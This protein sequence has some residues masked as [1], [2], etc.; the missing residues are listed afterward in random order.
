MKTEMKMGKSAKSLLKKAAVET[1]AE[2]RSV[3]PRT[4]SPA[5]TT[6][7][8]AARDKAIY[9]LDARVEE[10]EVAKF[11]TDRAAHAER[12]FQTRKIEAP[13]EAHR[14]EL[15]A[16]PSVERSRAVCGWRIK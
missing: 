15:V 16:S 14:D 7:A 3:E 11:A 6:K 4:E 13:A 1:A 8:T 10:L 2:I 9:E 5:A 12:R